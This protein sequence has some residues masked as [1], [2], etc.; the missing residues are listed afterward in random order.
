[1][2]VDAV[3]AIKAIMHPISK[4]IP[5]QDAHRSNI[6]CDLIAFAV[7]FVGLTWVNQQEEVS[8][9][10]RFATGLFLIITV[11]LITIWCAVTSSQKNK[12]P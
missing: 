9:E 8:A 6:I 12:A 2:P 3:G 7:L 10:N 1:M 4:M 5:K 11:L